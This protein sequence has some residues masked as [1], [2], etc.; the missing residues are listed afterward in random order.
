MQG[1]RFCLAR[2][3]F[4]GAEICELIG[5]YVLDELSTKFGKKNVGLYRDDGLA[6]LNNCKGRL[7]DKTRKELSTI[8]ETFKIT[9][10]ADQKIGNFIDI[11]FNLHNNKYQPYRKPNDDPR[12]IHSHSNHSPSTTKQLPKT[13][14]KRISTLSSA[15]L[16]IDAAVP[17][18]EEA[19]RL[20][21]F[22]VKLK[23]NPED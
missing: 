19:L 4:D 11:T 16:S 10:V 7:A 12:F 1:N 13:I 17:I 22:N 23:Y 8:Y 15:F 21:N 6:I 20:S 9:T 14:N 18:Y 2:G 3:S 5:L